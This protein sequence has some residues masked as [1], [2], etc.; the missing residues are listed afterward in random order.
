MAI[1]PIPAGRV[2]DLL[3]R[4]RL[5]AQLNVDQQDILRLQDQ[6]STQRRF[7]LPSEDAPAAARAAAIQDLLQRKDQVKTNLGTNQSYLDATDSALSNVSSL[8]A[9]IRS[10]ALGVKDSAASDL[11]RKAAAQEVS[12]AIQQLVDT[13]NQKFRGRFLFAGSRPQQQPFENVGPFVRYQGNQRELLSY[14]D[15]DLLFATNANG[16]EVF[17]AI[18][19][20]VLGTANLNPVLRTDTLLADLRGGQGV[21]RGSIVIS[22]GTAESTIDLS[23]ART[24]GD[25]IG[26]IQAHPPAGRKVTVDLTATG[27]NVSLDTA[28]G[29]NLT[30]VDTGGGT[31]A[32]EL[33]IA[34]SVGVGTGPVVGADVDP[35]I[36]PTTPLADLLGVRAS[37]KLASSGADNDLVFEATHNGTTHNGVT[38][39]FVDNP[40]VNA[41][42]ETVS[43]NAGAGTLVFQ[44]DAGNTTANDIVRTLNNDPV[45]GQ[46]FR[47]HLDTVDTAPLSTPGNGIVEVSATA[48]TAGGGGADLDRSAGLRISSGGV[49]YNITFDDAVT[50]EDL[51]NKING[52]NSGA[53]AEINA[54]GTGINVHSRQSGADFSI[55]ENG[56]QTAAQLGLR[57]FTTASRLEDLNHGFGVHDSIGDDF[58]IQRKD[59][60]RLSFDVAGIATI[61]DL[62]AAVNNHPGNQDPPHQVI[63]R[64][65][66]SGNGIELV[67]TDVATAAP[68]QVVALN[69]SLV[70][71]D[72]GLI[73]AGASQSNPA[74]VSGGS[75]TITGCDVNPQE[76]R[77]VFNS[78]VRLREAL[79]ANDAAQINRAIELLDQDGNKVNLARAE[80]GARQQGLDVLHQRLDDEIVSLKSSLSE[81][82]DVDLP[83]AI[84]NFKARQVAYQAALQT[85]AAISKL[86]LLNYL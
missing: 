85:T 81:E 53:L 6:L 5:L 37:A 16:N 60:K 3:S 52:S 59:G 2:S 42:S 44:I 27:F 19:D 4:Q 26:L 1:I 43:Y 62:I 55:G 35:R 24:V 63:A 20:P 61:G 69:N 64:L 11:Q 46:L 12:R 25:V 9:S 7:S 80:I 13:G 36:V 54:A 74:A 14:A 38:I 18:S 77:G 41:G 33:G 84:S 34:S 79:L 15:T 66:Q 45:A 49:V 75:E 17:G 65:A 32:A 67:T 50:V 47:V 23:N 86:S 40:G 83:E 10:T 68:F 73:P 29:G 51:L 48:V 21:S 58:V 30:I 82:V 71:Q 76:V 70:A 39:S 56:G 57:T 31:I 72:L 28:G 22:D 78:L 8:L